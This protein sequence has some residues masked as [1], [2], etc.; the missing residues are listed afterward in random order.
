MQTCDI[1]AVCLNLDDFV[2]ASL[3]DF[4]A[5][6]LIELNLVRLDRGVKRN[7]AE[8]KVIVCI[9][10]ESFPTE[11]TMEYPVAVDLDVTMGHVR[12]LEFLQIE[13]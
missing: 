13:A 2:K 10:N 5:H 4:L 8:E 3:T 9:F 1:T 12:V 6:I 11:E 7:V